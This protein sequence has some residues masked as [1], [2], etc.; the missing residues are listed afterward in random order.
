[1]PDFVCEHRFQF[2]LGKLG[3]EC[4]EKDNFAKTSE[5][6][7]EGV[8]VMRPF[9]AVHYF[10]APGW[11]IGAPRQRK[12]AFAQGGTLRQRRELVEERHD[13]RRGDEQ[14]KQ[15]ERDYGCRCPNP[16]I[17]AS[18]RDQLQHQCKQWKSK[19]NR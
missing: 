1:M 19:Q 7:E 17:W 5:P 6:G 9:A 2:W 18:P 12:E 3:Y 14:Q 16:P 10:D 4:V 13:H 11:K 15:L 8:G